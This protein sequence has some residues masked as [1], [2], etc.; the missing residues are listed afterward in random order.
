MEIEKLL[1]KKG[2]WKLTVGHDRNGEWTKPTI[3]GTVKWNRMLTHILNK[4]VNQ[5][6]T[7]EMILKYINEKTSRVSKV[8]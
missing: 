5:L 7:E 6:I 4:N 3:F 2:Y 8:A 1:F